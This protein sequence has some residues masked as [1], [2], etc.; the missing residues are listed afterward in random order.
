[1]NPHGTETAKA[2]H[3]KDRIARASDPVLLETARNYKRPAW[4]Q[5]EMDKYKSTIPKADLLFMVLK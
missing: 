4:V 5:A 1:M 2:Q 3:E